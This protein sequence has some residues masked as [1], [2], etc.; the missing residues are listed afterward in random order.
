[1]AED[2]DWDDVLPGEPAQGPAGDGAVA[3]LP[4]HAQ[5]GGPAGP[6]VAQSLAVAVA[7][8]AAAD[9]RVRRSRWTTRIPAPRKRDRLEQ[10]L[11]AARMRDHKAARR[12]VVERKKTQEMFREALARMRETGILR[13]GCRSLV[14]LQR[15]SCVIT[16]PSTRKSLV[17]PYE[18]MLAIAFSKI[19]RRADI[20]RA[21]GV[22]G[23]SAVQVRCLVA[24]CISAGDQ[25]VLNAISDGEP[26]LHFVSGFSGDATS[27]Q[28]NLPFVG[29]DAQLESVTRSTWH[30]MVSWQ[31]FGW[32]TAT[33]V[34]RGV[35]QCLEMCRPNV[36]LSTTETAGVIYRT[37]FH[38]PQVEM[39]ASFENQC[40]QKALLRKAI[41]FDLDG[42]SANPLA[43]SLRRN[44]VSRMLG[45]EVMATLR[46]CGCHVE[47]LVSN[48]FLDCCDEANLKALS[49]GVSF[50]KMGGA[51]LRLIHSLVPYV[52][53]GCHFP[54]SDL[55]LRHTVL[56]QSCVIT[57][58]GTSS[59]SGRKRRPRRTRG[60]RTTRWG[61]WRRSR[62]IVRTTP[63]GASTSLSSTEA[64]C[65]RTERRGIILL[66]HITVRLQWMSK[67]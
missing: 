39:F 28:L 36:P 2:V 16:I 67:R 38:C 57:R 54:L 10:L 3:A 49:V 40:L 55:L 6:A 66:L 58:C 5:L 29:I 51:F 53:N 21:F 1:M 35:W 44:E 63:L 34:Q 7:M 12:T 17:L 59:I 62:G 56:S 43:A 32:A 20:A 46:H 61:L 47:N 4:P 23:A 42:F 15:N 52:E 50:M 25:R 48:A 13:D 11:A 22:D 24:R 65:G 33:D 31:T 18:A 14:H 30:N 19:Q 41:H 8:P 45:H 26:L 37:W 27:E 64:A 9:V 60:A